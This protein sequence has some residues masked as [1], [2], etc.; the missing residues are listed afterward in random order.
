MD[1]II[2]ELFELPSPLDGH[3]FA[4]ERASIPARDWLRQVGLAAEKDARLDE[5]LTASDI[6]EICQ[7]HS[8]DI[9]AWPIMRQM[10]RP[11]CSELAAL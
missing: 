8:L 5:S 6:L 3:E 4:Q 9:P 2:Q 11:P 1:W 7:G 10:R